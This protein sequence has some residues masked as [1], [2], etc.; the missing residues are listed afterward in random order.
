MRVSIQY[1]VHVEGIVLVIHRCNDLPR[2]AR[3]QEIQGDVTHL[4]VENKNELQTSCISLLRK[5]MKSEQKEAIVLYVHDNV[6]D[7]SS[8]QSFFGT[9]FTSF[10]TVLVQDDYPGTDESGETEYLLCT[11]D[12]IV[13]GAYFT[14]TK[15]RHGPSSGTF[16]FFFVDPDFDL[17]DEAEED[18]DFEIICDDK[19]EV[20]LK[21]QH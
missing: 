3:L 19:D 13:E 11:G 5:M 17:D 9:T 18:D 21:P 10:E 16:K 1:Q 6:I 12:D 8:A 2:S 20:W 7:K 15:N 4:H 14:V